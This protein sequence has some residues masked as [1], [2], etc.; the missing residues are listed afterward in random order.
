MLVQ[1]IPFLFKTV[2]CRV[3][4]KLCCKFFPQLSFQHIM[5]SF[6]TLAVLES[7]F[8][9]VSN[10]TIFGSFLANS[11]FGVV[12]VCTNLN[13]RNTV[14]DRNTFGVALL[15]SPNMPRQ[16]NFYS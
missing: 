15:S 12:T 8:S 2:L 5:L 7:F 10:A 3:E 14:I 6:K 1:Y 9:N 11:V 16:K 13:I 4:E